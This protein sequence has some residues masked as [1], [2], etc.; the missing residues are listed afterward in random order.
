MKYELEKRSNTLST[1]DE[2]HRDCFLFDSKEF[3]KFAF[4]TYSLDQ[5][6]R[7]N[8]NMQSVQ[9]PGEFQYSP[10]GVHSRFDQFITK[11]G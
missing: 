3:R 7:Q 8:S 1:Y 5:F 9:L 10:L 4:R 6:Y 11:K 2:I